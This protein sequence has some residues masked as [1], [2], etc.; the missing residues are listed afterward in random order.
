MPKKSLKHLL[1]FLED[2]FF[3][4]V[5]D[6]SV[7]KP[8]VADSSRVRSPSEVSVSKTVAT[9]RQ[10]ASERHGAALTPVEVDGFVR[11]TEKQNWQQLMVI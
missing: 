8:T 3:S 7:A 11:R 4:P 2:Y 9:A 5:D 1:L 6:L 10:D